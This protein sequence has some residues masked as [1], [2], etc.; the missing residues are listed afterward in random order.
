[1][2]WGLASL[3][4]EVCTL[5]ARVVINEDE[6]VLM[7][8]EQC[9]SE[10][11]G[12]IAMD[13]SSGIGWLVSSPTVGQ[14]GC[15]GLDEAGEKSTLSVAQALRGVSG[16]ARKGTQAIDAGM[17]PAVEYSCCCDGRHSGDVT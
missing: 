14:V 10:W 15:G 12:D 4:H 1:M 8:A 2:L 9:G 16:Q 3:L 13:E 6:N 11:S 5:E 17:K 7:A